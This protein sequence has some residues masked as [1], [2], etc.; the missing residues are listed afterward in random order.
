MYSKLSQSVIVSLTS[1]G[2]RLTKIHETINSLLN[3]TVKPYKIVLTLFTEDIVFLPE[4][5]K[6]LESDGV[7]EIIFTDIDLKSHK[8]YFYVMKK[9]RGFPIITV[10]DDC[11]YTED[12][13]ESLLN[14]Y[15]NHPNCVS[16]R[17]VHLMKYNEKNF[18]YGYES[19]EKNIKTVLTPSFDLLATGCGGILYPPNCFNLSDKNIEEI[20]QCIT[21]DDIYLK[22]MEQKLSIPIVYVPNKKNNPSMLTDFYNNTGLYKTN[23]TQNDIILE[24]FKIFKKKDDNVNFCIIHYNTPKM[25]ERLIK[26]INKY[27]PNSNIYIF[28]NSDKFPFVYKQNNIT[29][30]DNTD[31][32]IL[33]FDKYFSS[34]KKINN[35]VSAKHCLSV[36]KC[37]DLI[38]EPFILLD[39]DTLLKKDISPL[40]DTN[41]FYV[42]ETMKQSCVNVY[43][44]VPFCCFIN[45][46]KCKQE[47]IRYFNEN[48]I[49]GH[50]NSSFDTGAYF[51]Y[52][53]K[54]FPHKDILFSEF[55]EHY[56]CGSWIPSEKTSVID[57]QKAHSTLTQ[58]EWLLK[59]KSL[60][61][62][63]KN[64][65]YTCITD[66]YD[67]LREP[68]YVNE[69]FDYICFTDN[70]EINKESKV[71]VTREIPSELKH[72]SKVKQQRCIK[73]CPHKYLSEY[74]VSV[75]VDGSINIRG[76]LKQLTKKL[77]SE[78]NNTI[79][80]G[81]HPQ[82]NCIYDEANACVRLK[83]DVLENI[84]PQIERYKKEG[85]PKQQGLVQTT[86]IIRRHNEPSCI[87]VMEMWKDELIKGSHRDQLSFNYALWKTNSKA[88]RYLNPKIFNSTYF[89]WC[90][91]THNKEKNRNI[92][93][94]VKAQ[95]PQTVK[96]PIATKTTVKT[97]QITPQNKEKSNTQPTITIKTNNIKER[98]KVKESLATKKDINKN[99]IS[100][101]NTTTKETV[102]NITILNPPPKKAV[103]VKTE[104]RP[105]VRKKKNASS[106]S[107]VLASFRR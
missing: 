66:G 59:N 45:V 80:I 57:A 43:R 50:D 17:R 73:I 60:W 27:T 86:V 91:K 83:K 99:K 15:I 64:V 5:I 75:W 65:V 19:F 87:D 94:I 22:Y 67:N 93:V 28:D 53:A 97:V 77:C 104:M 9:Y 72:L 63:N 100:K 25:T 92:N 3:Q 36:D 85:F 33:D 34:Y 76:D 90:S 106:G 40:F 49:I 101:P 71:W 35:L 96:Q 29:I 47:N 2:Q 21:A 74:D 55:V 37:F 54:P 48:Y 26:S 58:D 41:L 82:R 88:L 51:L 20:R 18:A 98:I 61:C 62:T 81:K 6:Q 7:I 44:L 105:L 14:S 70:A 69:N 4:E 1:Y 102:K 11:I 78:N 52:K 39:S 31:G 79:F 46:E 8:K 23:I 95:Q 30:F 89:L 12:F 10:D 103:A 13:V 42:G 16:A 68:E 24:K 32:K 107:H 84:S 56:K 38:N